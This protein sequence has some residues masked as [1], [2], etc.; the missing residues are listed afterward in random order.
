MDP[1]MRKHEVEVRRRYGE[2]EECLNKMRE[3]GGLERFAMGY[4][5]FGPQVESDG[6]IRWLEWAPA[7]SGLHLIGDFNQWSKPGMQFRK[8]EY[9]RWELV[10]PPGPDGLPGIRH[11]DKVKILV[12]GE[13]RISPWASYVVQPPKEKQSYEGTALCHHFWNPPPDQSYVVQ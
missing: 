3:E 10:V 12:N 1:C 13:D 9:G 5:M 2:Y 8:L 6:S 11:G 4:K 7:A